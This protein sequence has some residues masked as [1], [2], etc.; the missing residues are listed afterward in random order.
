MSNDQTAPT[1]K[2]ESVPTGLNP[3]A[4][5]GERDSSR[6]D[7]LDRALEEI[8]SREPGWE[9]PVIHHLIDWG[10][11][12]NAEL[13]RGTVDDRD[14]DVEHPPYGFPVI[15][16]DAQHEREAIMKYISKIAQELPATHTCDQGSEKRML[17]DIVL[18]LA[19]GLHHD[20]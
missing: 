1:S 15:K 19:E 16:S 13:R 4:E 3:A 8:S 20:Q 18:D 17:L 10:R 7:W 11:E 5:P 6:E 12:V 14:A 9:I 2:D